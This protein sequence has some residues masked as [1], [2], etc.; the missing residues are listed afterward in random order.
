MST[1]QSIKNCITLHGSAQI[2]VE[3][4]SKL[5][6]SNAWA[7]VIMAPTQIHYSKNKDCSKRYWI[8]FQNTELILFYFNVEFIHPRLLRIHSNMA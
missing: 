3:Y 8:S 6:C 7:A 5:S 2:I 1:A 4:L